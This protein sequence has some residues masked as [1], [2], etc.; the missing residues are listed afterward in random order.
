MRS[1]LPIARQ[2]GTLPPALTPKPPNVPRLALS[3]AELAES[4]SVSLC[5]LEK[6]DLPHFWL[7][8]RRLYPIAQVE[9]WLARQTIWPGNTA[10]SDPPP[11]SEA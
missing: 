1:S 9:Q 10:P 6:Q 2:F 8:K 5:H 7:G 4:L 3:A 11:P